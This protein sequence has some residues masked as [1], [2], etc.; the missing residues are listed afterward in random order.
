MQ[1]LGILCAAILLLGGRAVEAAAQDDDFDVNAAAAFFALTNTPVGSGTIHAPGLV[2]AAPERRLRTQFGFVDEVGEIAQRSLLV[3]LDLPAGGG[4]LG[5][6][7]GVSDLTCDLSEIED[8]LGIEVDCASLIMLGARWTGR[9]HSE[10]LGGSSHSVLHL[11]IEVAAGGSFG[12]YFEASDGV[13][14]ISVSSRNLAAGVSLPIVLS[15]RSGSMTVIP[16]I[17]PGFGYGRST[18]EVE[19][20]GEEE[21]VTEGGVQFVLAAGLG[22]RFGESRFGIDA[23][24]RKIFADDAPV[25]LG[26][27]ASIRLR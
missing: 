24:V 9:L 19:F 6:E 8:A 17:A 12:D 2:A 7:A 11:A 26:L 1:R 18:Q 5:I 15:A 22:L 3:G 27:G 14:T 25:V 21:D 13:E 16:I 20:E 23:G 10:P 4:A